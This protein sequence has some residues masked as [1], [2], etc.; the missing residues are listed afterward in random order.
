MDLTLKA[1]RPLKMKKPLCPVRGHVFPHLSWLVS[2]LKGSP[3]FLAFGALVATKNPLIST[4]WDLACRIR[5]HKLVHELA[6]PGVKPRS[7]SPI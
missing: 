7:T 3:F 6:D 2:P 5:L 4:R 1:A